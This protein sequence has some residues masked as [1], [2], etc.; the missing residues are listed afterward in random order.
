MMNTNMNTNMN[1]PSEMQSR[2]QQAGECRTRITTSGG[3]AL[4]SFALLPLPCIAADGATEADS[5]VP[6]AGRSLEE[7]LDTRVTSVSREESTVG[8]SAAAVFVITPEMIHRS[9][10]TT[11]PE[12]LRMVP[13]INVSK[14][15][16]NKWAVG[17]RGFADRFVG[18]LQVQIDG[19]TVYTPVNG[20]VYWD[21][22]DYPLQ[23]VER[24]EVIRGPGAS[25]WG[26][27]AVN[28]IIN[29]ITKP[30]KDTQGGLL[31]GGAGTEES[32][33]VT[34]RWGGQVGKNIQYRVYGKWFER[35]NGFNAKGDARDDWRQGRFGFRVDWQ[36]QRE[37][38][39][40][41]EGEYF[42]GLSGRRDLRAS[43]TSPSTGYIVTNTEDEESKGGNLQL[44][45]THQTG[46][47]SNWTLQMYYDSSNRRGTGGT[48]DFGVNTFD[49]DFQQEFRL[50]EIQKIVWGAQY[51]LE[52]ILWNGSTGFDNAFATRPAREFVERTLLGLFVQDE[53][54]IVKDRFALFLGAKGEHNDYTGFEFQPSGRLLWT[55][56][57]KQ[58]L[59]A[60]VS[61]AVRTPSFLENDINITTLPSKNSSGTTIFPRITGNPA[62]ASETLI[63]YELG[64]RAQ[65]TEKLSFDAALF[66]NSYD[67]LFTTQSGTSY[68]DAMTGALTLPVNRSN[69]GSGETYGAEITATWQITDWWR[70]TGNYSYLKLNLHADRTLS[71][72]SAA[73][74]E[75]IERQSPQN[76]VYVRSSFDLPGHVQFDV[77]GRYVDSIS[78]FSP[79]IPSYFTMDARLAWKPRPNVEFAIVGQNLL[80]NHH[81]EFGTSSLVRSPLVEVERSVYATVTLKF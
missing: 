17:S 26:A 68:V 63:A 81:A 40:M 21:T 22:F 69:S 76:Q 46:K 5:P 73:S 60:A 53:I 14:I 3:I 16:S 71:A 25:I 43:P 65:V 13:G 58:S 59:W 6:L 39:I 72:S 54:S 47:D 24:I 35:D 49:I 61:R 37:D 32:G 4:L 48:F 19:R 8:R 15:D 50:G 70:V 45:W 44:K 74:F 12:L 64:Y 55:P 7:L 41:V 34:A 28:G 29:V 27:N 66:Y 51:R 18:K 30:A 9:G 20:G 31:S 67:R 10:A 1:A 42:I 36:P 80:Q 57:K 33:M 78:G 38:S 56:T 75:R 11:F 2:Q 77:T 79:G 62:L 52:R 23:D